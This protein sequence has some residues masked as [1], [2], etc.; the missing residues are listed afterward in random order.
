MKSDSVNAI[1]QLCKKTV[2]NITN[3]PIPTQDPS[4]KTLS[5]P[6]RRN[7]LVV[8]NAQIEV[9]NFI[10]AYIEKVE[11]DTHHWPT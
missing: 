7:M 8:K 11:E 1:K 5:P 3:K 4:G 9:V 2:E 6:E 10:I